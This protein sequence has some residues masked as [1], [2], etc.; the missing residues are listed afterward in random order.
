MTEYITLTEAAALSI[1]E[2]EALA[3]EFE[4]KAL[5]MRYRLSRWWYRRAARKLRRECGKLRIMYEL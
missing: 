2:G 5:T 1:E 3:A 4:A